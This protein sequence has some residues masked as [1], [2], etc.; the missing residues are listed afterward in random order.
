MTSGERGGVRLA[1]YSVQWQLDESCCCKC[2]VGGRFVEFIQYSNC[3]IATI[4]ILETEVATCLRFKDHYI[5]SFDRK[6][7]QHFPRTKH[8]RVL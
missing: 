3:A 8:F 2:D 5:H 4:D 6:T 7:L 1:G